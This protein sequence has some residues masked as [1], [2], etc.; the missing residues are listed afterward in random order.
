MEALV[1]L[2]YLLALLGVGVGARRVGVLTE[3]RTG[4]LNRT[5]FYVALPALIFSS[6]YDRSLGE[7]VSVSLVGGFLVVLG[8]TAALAWL[9]HRRRASRERRSVAVVGSY[10]SNMGFLGLPLVGATLG[11]PAA[12]TA[13]VV[14]GIGVLTQTPLTVASLVA[15]TDADASATAELRRV[16]TNPVVLTLVAGLVASQVGVTLPG[17]AATGLEAVAAF[18]LPLALLAI[19]GSLR[20]SRGAF[21]PRL[22]GPVVATKVFVMPAL[23]WV[24]FTAL[25]VGSTAAAAAVMMF[26]MPTA[27][28]T[29]VYA[30]ELGGDARLASLNVFASTVV[31]L[32]TLAVLPQ[33]LG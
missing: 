28:S 19:G 33:I 24:V 4:W 30:R 11:D 12:A 16:A 2:G 25:G 15:I 29:F 22:T 10:H 8:A 21:D 3:R 23:A 26:A 9:V 20:V 5:A 32:G 1:R 27:V 13:S 31:S 7:L 17:T 14:L 6:T 18:A